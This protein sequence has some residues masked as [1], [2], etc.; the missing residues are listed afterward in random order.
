M[1]HPVRSGFVR[2]RG[3]GLVQAPAFKWVPVCCEEGALGRVLALPGRWCSE[4]FRE[5]LRVRDGVASVPCS[6][7]LSVVVD[8]TDGGPRV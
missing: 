6:F 2:A 3:S 7:V 8:G 4:C 5:Y 1:L